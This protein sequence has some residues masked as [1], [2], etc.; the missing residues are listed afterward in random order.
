MEDLS[1]MRQHLMCPISLQPMQDPVTAPTGITYDRRAIERWLAAGHATC[2]VTGQPLALADLTPNHT[3][4]RLIQS[5][6][7]PSSTSTPPAPDAG[8]AKLLA[9]D[10]VEQQQ[11]PPEVAAADVVV[12]KLLCT[13]AC[14]S[15]DVLREAAEVASESDVARRYMVD[16]GVLQRVLRVIVSSASEVIKSTYPEHQ[17]RRSLEATRTV[18]A[19]LDLVRAL[20]VSGDELRP[21]VV[22]DT[23]VHNLLDAVTDVLV[24]LEPV[25]TSG[26]DTDTARESV[27]RLLDSVTE[28]ASSAVLERLRPELFRA[29]TAVVRDRVSPGAMR[30]ALRVLLH[31]CPLGR[32]RALVVDAGAAHEAIELELDAPPPSSSPASAGGGGRRVT[33]LAM[34]LLAELCACA[35]GRAAVA[36]HPAGVAVV[37]RRLLRVSAAAD[38]CAVRVLAAVGGRAASPEVLREMARVGA[39]GKLC[40]VLQADCDA[41][42]KEAARAVLRLHSGVWSGSPCVSA[43]LLSRYL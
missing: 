2:P 21:L 8:E 32:N 5:W 39:V 9:D 6:R 14:P 28:A 26:G 29:V 41:A 4:R 3:L 36:A 22:A 31:A 11:R 7:L 33:E 25:G 27:V 43:Y 13:V 40:C 23:H 17:V 12:K 16:A 19:G 34:A 1:G 10:V 42:V 15:V 37:A 38:A 24:A 18:E 20:A 35:D 30:C